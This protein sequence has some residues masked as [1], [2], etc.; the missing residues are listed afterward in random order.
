MNLKQVFQ[1]IPVGNP[2]DIISAFHPL[3]A[4]YRYSK[5]FSHFSLRLG[6]VA[7]TIE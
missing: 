3:V 7:L 2:A 4:S 1:R 5:I 6:T